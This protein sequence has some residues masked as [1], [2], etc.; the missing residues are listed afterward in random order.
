[1]E[2]PLATTEQDCLAMIAAAESSGAGLLVG[3]VERFNPVIQHLAQ[4]LAGARVFAIDVRRMSSVSARI[5]DVDV[6]SDLMVHDLDIVRTLVGAVPQHVRAVGVWQDESANVDYAA[7]SLVFPRGEIASL[8]S[9]RITQNKIRHYQVTCDLGSITADL[10]GRELLIHRQSKLAPLAI[11][12]T[13]FTL[14]LS[15]DRVFVRDAEPLFV[16]L[17]HF[18]DVARGISPPLVSGAEALESLRLVWA[19]QHSLAQQRRAS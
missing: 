12:G 6:V 19:V 13:E 14:D 3:H 8:T 9:S 10:L 5:T 7:A 1:V 15:V 11:A 2:K 18:V 4:L 17:S 16:E